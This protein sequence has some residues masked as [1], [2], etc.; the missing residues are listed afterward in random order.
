[1]QFSAEPGAGKNK[2]ARWFASIT[3]AVVTIGE[4]SQGIFTSGVVDFSAPCADKC[5]AEIRTWK[6]E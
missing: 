1:M 2:N 3:N 6:S 5:G 4:A